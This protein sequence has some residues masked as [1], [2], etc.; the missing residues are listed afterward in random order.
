MDKA[1]YSHFILIAVFNVWSPT[2]FIVLLR[3]VL[4]AVCFL[5][6]MNVVYLFFSGT[7][8]FSVLWIPSGWFF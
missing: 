1:S 7:A 8:F 2:F 4:K 6:S 3:L 5:L